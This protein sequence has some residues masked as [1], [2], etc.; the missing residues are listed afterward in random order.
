MTPAVRFR[1]EPASMG[2]HLWPFRF[3]SVAVTH[4]GC[5]RKLNED[6]CLDRPE[7]GL[8]AV[9]DGMGGHAAGDVASETVI[10]V[11]RTVSDFGSPF[12]FRRAVREALTVANG[13][14]QAR[15]DA[16]FLDSIGSTVVTLM[17]HGGHY[18]CMWAGD[19]RAYLLRGSRLERITRDHSLVADMV[20]GGALT[21]TEARSHSAANVVTRA[22]GAFPS[23]DLEG[24][25]GAINAGDRF[26]LCSDGLA[27]VLSD[28][29]ITKHI[30]AG[31]ASG[32][33]SALLR[34]CLGNGAPDNV[35]CV[36]IDVEPAITD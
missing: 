19:S 35:T 20:N 10:R 13:E 29:D 1:N 3:R 12:S 28:E 7:V 11:L 9:A 22:I 33:I 24:C 17:A 27:A 23:V 25:Y 6:A 14:L 30:R 32:A 18:A 36:L 16:E 15:A 8:W 26:L 21:E 5:V 4:P 2:Q 31:P 34:S